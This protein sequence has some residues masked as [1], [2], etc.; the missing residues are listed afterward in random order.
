MIARNN[1][2]A[3]EV[4]EKMRG[5]L[6][7]VKIEHWFKPDDF[8]AKMRLCSR[9]VLAPGSSIGEHTHENEDEI[10]IVLS[11]TAL[12]RENGEE[13]RLNAGD[14]ALTKHGGTHSVLNDG[15]EELV[16]A[17]IIVQY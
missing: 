6:G 13:I 1:E 2:L 9:L 17:A 15:T 12:L 10:Y 8:G 16:T 14:A 5:G 4:R 11:G 7:A 3:T